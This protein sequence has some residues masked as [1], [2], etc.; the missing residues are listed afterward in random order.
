MTLSNP[1]KF[2]TRFLK[3]HE[4]KLH[5]A[6]HSHHF[7][8]DITREA[9]LQYWDDCAELSDEKWNK[10]FSEVIPKAQKHIA[11]ILKLKHPE[12]ITFAPNT[13]EL[14]SRVLSLFLG[15]PELKILTTSSEFHSWKR[16]FMRLEELSQVSVK[17]IDTSSLLKNREQFLQNFR[18]ELSGNY[19]LIY[20]SQVFF[21]SGLALTTD[22]L[23]SLVNATPKESLFVVDGYH[24]FAALPT[25]L[26]A[27]E[28]RLF[29]LG[30]GYKYAQAGEGVGFMVMPKGNWRPAHTGWF[31]EIGELSQLSGQKIGYPKDGMSFMGAT[32]DPSGL[33]RFNAVWELFKGQ[34]ITVDQIHQYVRGLQQVFLKEMPAN[35]EKHWQLTP[36]FDPTLPHH[37]HFLTFEALTIDEAEK[38]QK[39][40]SQQNIFIDRRGKRLR[41]GFGLYQDEQDVKE[42]CLRLQKLA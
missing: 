30:G 26:S 24:G 9:Q 34:Q 2:Y 36:L 35:F 12:Q 5:F 23:S 32:Q 42:L 41:F 40:L 19:D 33:Y 15:R 1:K 8:P 37:G 13:H 14:A 11:G 7:W 31:A 38:C 21:D 6:A 3:G 4:G 28:G 10:I 22:E 25:D 39:A 27:L 16:Q 20:L 18:A 17:Q 29:Y